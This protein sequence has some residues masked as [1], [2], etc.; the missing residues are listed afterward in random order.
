MPKTYK[1]FV[2]VPSF[3]L[4]K[5]GEIQD[6]DKVLND[7]ADDVR[8]ISDYANFVVRNDELL[9]DELESVSHI[10]QPAFAGRTLGLNLPEF[11]K[12]RGTGESRREELFRYNVVSSARSWQARIE[13]KIGTSARYKS[14]GYKRTVDSTAPGYGEPHLNLASVDKLFAKIENNPLKDGNI[15]LNLVVKKQWFKLIF[16]FEGERFEGSTKICLPYVYL[17]DGKLKFSFSVEIDVPLIQWSGDYIIGVDAGINTYATVTVVNRKTGRVVHTTT[18]S[19]R[20]RSLCKSVAASEKQVVKLHK[21]D[22]HG[23]KYKNKRKREK[24]L[25]EIPFHRETASRKKREMAILAGQEIAYLSYVFDNAPVVLEDLTFRKNTMANGRWNYGV[26][27]RWTQHFVS[28]NGGWVIISNAAYTS[29]ICHICGKM[30]KID[31]KEWETFRCKEHGEMNRDYNASINIAFRAVN[32]IDKGRAT[33]A[34]NKKLVK[35][36]QPLKTPVTRNTLRYP[37][38]DRTKSGP[39]RKRPPKRTKEVKTFTPPAIS[40]EDCATV[41]ADGQSK[42]QGI[43]CHVS[44]RDFGGEGTSCYS[45]TLCRVCQGS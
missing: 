43:H 34:K 14:Q 44:D 29:K 11:L 3:V 6:T 30:G 18:L 39:T 45:T 24:A 20:H 13:D 37:K 42:S 28:Q 5:N 22:D 26:F 36:R 12:S 9:L 4:N 23:Y 2:A 10:K 41:I 27:K 33:R 38:P 17:R 40:T 21:K 8:T 25:D 35:K 19:Q 31:K 16:P 15:V 1:A 7:F 32:T